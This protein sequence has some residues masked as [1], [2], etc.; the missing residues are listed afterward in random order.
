MLIFLVQLSSWMLFMWLTFLGQFPMNVL[1]YVVQF[2]YIML[3][4][5]VAKENIK[6]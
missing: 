5:V 2:N 6:I 4:L 3:N 1:P